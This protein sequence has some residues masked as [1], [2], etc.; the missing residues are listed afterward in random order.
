MSE[1]GADYGDM[2]AHDLLW[3]GCADSALD[4]S[5]RLAVVPMS[6]EARGL[7]AGGR[8]VQRLVGAG[9]T[10]S[11]AVVALIAE[12]ERAH[13]AVGVTWFAR[14]CSALGLQ[15]GPLFRQWLLSLNPDLLK[16]PFNHKERNLVLLPRDWYDPTAWPAEAEAAVAPGGGGPQQQAPAGSQLQE[17]LRG[18]VRGRPH[19]RRAGPLPRLSEA[20]LAALAERLAVFAEVE[21]SATAQRLGKGAG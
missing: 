4:V 2:D 7:D 11:A 15:P 13:V 9:D 18:P 14:L 12:E 21:G 5:A 20:Q 10:R 3:Q 17:K 6:Q 8:L 1:L 19:P 16:G